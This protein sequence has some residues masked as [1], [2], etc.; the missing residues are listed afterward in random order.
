LAEE[1][2]TRLLHS[3]L[4]RP[5]EAQVWKIFLG[6]LEREP[7]VEQN[8]AEALGYASPRHHRSVGQDVP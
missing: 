8:L 2:K 4:P 3:D 7:C 1:E 6:L 5:L